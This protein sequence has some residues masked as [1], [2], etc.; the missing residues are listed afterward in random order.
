MKVV[1]RV[2]DQALVVSKGALGGMHSDPPRDRGSLAE[3]IFFGKDEAEGSEVVLD[4]SVSD[5][6]EALR[7]A[8][9]GLE[10]LEEH[11]RLAAEDRAANAVRC[12]VCGGWFD[13]R[14]KIKEHVDGRGDMCLL[15]GTVAKVSREIQ[16]PIEG[17]GGWWEDA[18]FATLKKGDVFRFKDTDDAREY[19]ALSDAYERFDERS[20]SGWLSVVVSREPEA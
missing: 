14:S 20:G 4:G 10:A 9:E 2:A 18:Q 8:L 12:D 16:R 19:R 5:L 3:V 17:G 13:R 1:L 6:Q 15:D 7:E 11:F